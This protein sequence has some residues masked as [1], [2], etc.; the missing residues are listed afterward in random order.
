M[1]SVNELTGVVLE[2]TLFEAAYCIFVLDTI[3]CLYAGISGIQDP[4]IMC[5][6]F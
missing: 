6:R 4:V 2:N 3:S 5:D 1:S